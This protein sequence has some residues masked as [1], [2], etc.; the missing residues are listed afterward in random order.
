MSHRISVSKV[1]MHAPL[2]RV[3]EAITKPELVKQWQYGTTLITDWQE[4]SPIIYRNEWDGNIYEQKG[5]ILEVEPQKQ[6]KFS[7]F[8]PRPG[9]EDL[10]EN[11]FTMIYALVEA[12]G[13]TTLTITQDDPREQE[14]QEQVEPDE[15]E[16][17][18][19]LSALRRLVE[20]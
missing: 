16:E 19:I 3:W 2:D 12:N 20:A 11:Y 6:V 7:L 9:L 15:E 1:T 14:L 4:G 10:P 5:T 18:A 17:N 13:K 8:A